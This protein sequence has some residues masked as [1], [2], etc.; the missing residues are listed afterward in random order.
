MREGAMVWRLTRCTP[1]G[2]NDAAACGGS[3]RFCPACTA[4]TD[5]AT[6]P[7][8]PR[9]PRGR[10]PLEPERRAPAEMLGACMCLPR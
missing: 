8:L 10:E 7:A 2:A 1:P 3:C 6:A 4:D 5:V 9:G